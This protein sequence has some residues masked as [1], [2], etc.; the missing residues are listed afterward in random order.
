MNRNVVLIASMQIAKNLEFLLLRTACN[1]YVIVNKPLDS[2]L[3]VYGVW[4]RE[5][6]LTL[7]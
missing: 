6:K 3:R 7:V 1:L 4:S 5:K 2:L